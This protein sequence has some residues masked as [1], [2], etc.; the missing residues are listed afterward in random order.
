MV[1]PGLIPRV[2]SHYGPTEDQ[3]SSIKSGAAL[4]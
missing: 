2:E 4:G 1:L 3:G